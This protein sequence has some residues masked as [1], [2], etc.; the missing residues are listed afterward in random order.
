MTQ[1][2]MVIV[3]SR[4]GGRSF[5]LSVERAKK[6]I[7]ALHDE[8]ESRGHEVRALPEPFRPVGAIPLFSQ[9][10]EWGTITTYAIPKPN[11]N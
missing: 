2:E 10:K 11:L 1:N 5:E 7:S 4:D 8:H 6:M 9:K 3:H